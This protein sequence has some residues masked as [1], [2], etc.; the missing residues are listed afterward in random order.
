VSG[1]PFTA[2][3]VLSISG[4]NT[5]LQGL[6]TIDYW[7]G[8]LFVVLGIIVAGTGVMLLFHVPGAQ[9]AALLAAFASLIISA[10]WVA[11]YH[12]FNLAAIG[13][14]LVAIYAIVR[15]KLRSRAGKDPLRT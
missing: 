6:Y 4:L 15:S 3:I 2:G 1:L 10:V 11:T 8:W 5:F 13:L 14:D 12:W 7:Q 9:V